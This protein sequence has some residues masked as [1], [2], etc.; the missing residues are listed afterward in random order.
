LRAESGS[1]GVVLAVLAVFT[2]IVSLLVVD[3]AHVVAVRAKL[4]TAAD[5]A[6]LAAAPVTFSPFGTDGSP[7]AVAADTAAANG[8]DLV[9][10]ECD[11]D[12]TWATRRVVVTVARSVDL[13]LLGGRRLSA[14]SS[15]EFQPV[16]LGLG[17]P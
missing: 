2:V 11:R 3:V 1:A 8:A 4:A 12:P 6:A 16:A 15:A 5:A 7:S 14:T 13:L 17:M 10:C 9:A